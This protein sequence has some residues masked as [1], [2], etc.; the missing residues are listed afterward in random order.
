MTD[1]EDTVRLHPA[2]LEETAVD[3]AD[4]M[5]RSVPTEA[6]PADVVEQ[7]NVVDSDDEEYPAS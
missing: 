7:R 6:D 4:E 2:E 3:V 1:P 5:S